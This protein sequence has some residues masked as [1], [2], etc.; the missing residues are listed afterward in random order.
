MTYRIQALD[1]S[2]KPMEWRDI[3]Y[4]WDDETGYAWMFESRPP[5]LEQDEPL[6]VVIQLAAELI[7]AHEARMRIVES[8]TERVVWKG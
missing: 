8:G 7:D 3:V 6:A 5:G 4:I 1:T 2:S